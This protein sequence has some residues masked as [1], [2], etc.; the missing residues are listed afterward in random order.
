MA[1]LFALRAVANGR[2]SWKQGVSEI[3][4]LIALSRDAFDRAVEKL[5]EHGL[6]GTRRGTAIEWTL[7]PSAFALAS[8]D[9]AKTTFLNSRKT[10]SLN[11]AK[12]HLEENLFEEEAPREENPPVNTVIRHPADAMIPAP[13]SPEDDIFATFFA[14]SQIATS[15]PVIETGRFEF[16]RE[17][18]VLLCEAPSQHA[19]IAWTGKDSALLRKFGAATRNWPDAKVESFL[20]EVS[21]MVQSE[22]PHRLF[23]CALRELNKEQASLSSLTLFVSFDS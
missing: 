18:A 10:P 22:T 23:A 16:L 3:L 8:D 4:P 7:L 15:P 17:T 2:R 19:T 20:V 14:A 5:I 11:S 21:D 6:I 1:V 13:A 9:S 12:S